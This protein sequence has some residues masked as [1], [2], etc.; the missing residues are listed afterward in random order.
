MSQTRQYNKVILP[1]DNIKWGEIVVA[2][3]KYKDIK[4]W[5]GQ[6]KEWDWNETGTRHQ[7]GIQTADLKEFINEVD[8]IIL[9]R[10]FENKLLTTPEL[11]NYLSDL[12][13]KRLYILPTEEAV[14]K[15][16]R[17]AAMGYRVG[18]LIH[19]TC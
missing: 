9:S 18:A 1:I 17:F 7:P 2:G 11:V 6:C 12:E 13:T 16:N 15:Y 3:K 4:I 8:Y 14:K 19:S 10:G 5:N